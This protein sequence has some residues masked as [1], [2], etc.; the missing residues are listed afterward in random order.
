MGANWESSGKPLSKEWK[1][2]E[3]HTCIGKYTEDTY[4][5]GRILRAILYV[6]QLWPKILPTPINAGEN[7]SFS[8]SNA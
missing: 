5:Y 4:L 3:I 8:S 1:L 7:T 6:W 2:H